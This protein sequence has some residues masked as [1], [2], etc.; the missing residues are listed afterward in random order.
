MRNR[1]KNYRLL[2]FTLIE[3][4]V[5]IAIIAILAS[6]LLPALN[7]ARMVAK[8][9]KCAGNMKT[10]GQSIY[11]YANDWNSYI[12]P[13]IDW[14]YSLREYVNMR[15]TE[16]ALANLGLVPLFAAKSNIFYCD[17]RRA[18][19]P[20][21][22]FSFAISYDVTVCNISPSTT[23]KG[24]YYLNSNGTNNSPEMFNPKKI[25]S[26][27]GSSII[28]TEVYV[29]A[30]NS[31][32]TRYHEYSYAAPGSFNAAFSPDYCHLNSANMLFTGGSVRNIKWNNFIDANWIPK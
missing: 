16:Y 17:S 4:L 5:V 23:N 29:G 31:V 11:M 9:T 2:N 3:L 28:V 6:M 30:F 19:Q 18:A 1:H 14:C 20:V 15:K 24:G 22:S 10:I 7:K 25:T 27:P 26:I 12:P 32:R 8:T 21:S 13:A